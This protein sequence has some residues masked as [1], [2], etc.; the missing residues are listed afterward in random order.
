MMDVD[1]EHGNEMPSGFAPV[2]PLSRVKK[3]MKS[4]KDVAMCSADAVA[5]T[6]MATVSYITTNSFPN[7]LH[8]LRKC[9]WNIL[10]KSYP[11][12]Y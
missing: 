12:R 9:F 4:D 5:V 11:R 7:T 8:N 6:A 10:V 2:F 3:I 1:E